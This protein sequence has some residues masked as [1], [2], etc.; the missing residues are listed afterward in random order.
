VVSLTRGPSIVAKIP[1]GKIDTLD[2]H[3]LLFTFLS[4]FRQNQDS[5]QMVVQLLCLVHKRI[6][7]DEAAS[8]VSLTRGP[9][10]VAKIPQN[11]Q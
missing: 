4:G 11:E 6:Y 2:T 8:V 10:I 1:G 5:Y 7:A 3:A 9:S